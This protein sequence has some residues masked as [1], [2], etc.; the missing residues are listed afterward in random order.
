MNLIEVVDLHK[1]FGHHEE[2]NA[3]DGV[4]FGIQPGGALGLIG[5][6]GS[7]KST[8]ARMLLGIE[9]PTSGRIRI[10]GNEVGSGRHG[11]HERRA[12][13]RR[14]QIVFQDPYLSLNP[15]A[16][17]GDAVSAV[18]RLHGVPRDEVAGR[19]DELLAAVGLGARERDS[20][21]GSLSGGQRQ[22]ASIAR[23]LAVDPRLLILDEAVSALDV[24]V[25][26][27]ILNLLNELRA[28]RGIAYLFITHNLAVVRYVTDDA[29]VLHHG[30]IVEQGPTGSVLDEPQHDYTR[31]LISAVPGGQRKD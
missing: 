4:S 13:A 20:L 3:V 25:Q 8:I 12:R 19:T 22:R 2:I 28:E 15:R 31:A 21:P 26:A 23:A 14:V 30:R 17:I 27:Q 7:G 29:I 9:R 1:R 16:R 11:A 10:E 5:E 6:S 24:S 18:C